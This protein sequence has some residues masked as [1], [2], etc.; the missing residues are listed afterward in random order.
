MLR[1]FKVLSALFCL[2]SF[3]SCHPVFAQNSSSWKIMKTS[4]SSMDEK[5]FQNFVQKIGEAVEQKKCR[6]VSQC[7]TSSANNYYH[8][9]PKGLRYYADC[10]DFPYYMRAYF[11]FKNGLPFSFATDMKRRNVPNN[12]GDLR[13]S[14]FGNEVAT[15]FD[16]ISRNGKFPDALKILNEMIPNETDS[17]N[18]RVNYQGNDIGALFA[19]FYPVKLNR[20]AITVGTILYDP[21]GHV[22]VVYKITED[23]K[24]YYVDAHPDNSL[25]T[26][27]FSIKFVRSNPGQGA[28]FKNWRPLQ[29]VG[30]TQHAQGHWQ[31][32]QIVATANKDLPLYGTE[33]FFGNQGQPSDWTQS[34]FLFDGRQVSYYEYVRLKMAIGNLRIYPVDDFR[35]TLKDLCQS[36]QDRVLAVEAGIKAGINDKE[37]PDRL[38][39]NIYGTQGEW[40][41]YSTPSRDAQLKVSFRDLIDQA[42][43]YMKKIKA[44]DPSIVYTG[45]DLPRELL[46]VYKAESAS[47]Q[48]SYT[49]TNGRSIILDLEQVRQRLF[50]LSFDPYHCVELRWGASSADELSSCRDN[51][52]KRLWYTREQRLRNQHIRRYD[53]K[54]DFSLEELANPT[55]NNG[56]ATAVDVDIERFLQGL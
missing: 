36:V 37:H 49:N 54:M 52:N 50:T 10:A 33:Q 3:Y 13:Y 45:N 24:L 42:D 31:G 41:T 18:F 17:G 26:G 9:D 14:A 53:I 25:T 40:E 16:V 46:D 56:V 4:W 35:S 2:I 19:D 15:K 29:L 51:Q 11:A 44:G 23:G 28:G 21:D 1:F 12:H 55:P 7:L 32:G 48:M 47:C 30:A 20:E 39:E 5:N 8:S 34:K 6:T 38:P 27:A 43:N 22:T